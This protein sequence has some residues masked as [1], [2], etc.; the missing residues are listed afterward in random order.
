[1]RL[2]WAVSCAGTLPSPGSPNSLHCR[3]C[4]APPPPGCGRPGVRSPWSTIA[5]KLIL[6][7]MTRK[8]QERCLV[9]AVRTQYPGR[10]S[11]SALGGIPCARAPPKQFPMELSRRDFLGIIKFRRNFRFKRRCDRSSRT[12][13]RRRIAESGPVILQF[14][15]SR[16]GEKVRRKGV[17]TLDGPAGS[18]KTVCGRLAALELGAVFISSGLY[19]RAAAFEALRRG[20]PLEDEVALAAVAEELARAAAAGTRLTSSRFALRSSSAMTPLSSG[21]SALGPCAHETPGPKPPRAGTLRAR[22]APSIYRPQ[23]FLSPARR[24]EPPGPLLTHP[25]MC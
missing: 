8:G 16:G 19:F 9:S 5:L 18:G 15:V 4:G 2:P 21:R 24:R 20:V 22:Q 14:P 13:L 11:L 10:D 25:G 3:G 6:K 12:F 23:Q 17:V 1:M 7:V